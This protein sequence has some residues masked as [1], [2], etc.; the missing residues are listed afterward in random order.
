MGGQDGATPLDEIVR[1]T[2]SNNTVATM[3]QRLPTNLTQAGIVWTGQHAYIFG[4]RVNAT[5]KCF[6]HIW[7]NSIRRFDPATQTFTTMNATLP[8]N[9]SGMAAVWSGQYVYLAGGGYFSCGTVTDQILRYDPA[10]DTLT[11]MNGK[12]T[13]AYSWLSAV[14]MQNKMYTFGGID[15]N[16]FGSPGSRDIIEYDPANDTAVRLGTQIFPGRFGSAAITDG[17]NALVF[18]GVFSVQNND[19]NDDVQRFTPGTTALLTTEMPS[20]FSAGRAFASAVFTGTDAYLIGGSNLAGQFDEIV[21]YKATPA[22]PVAL[23]ASPGPLPQQITLTWTAPDPNSY[24]GPITGYV[25]EKTTGIQTA[26]SASLSSTR[27]RLDLPPDVQT[28]IDSCSSGTMY[29]Y[30]VSAKNLW[31]EGPQSIAASALCP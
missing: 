20:H 2:P 27:E 24:S 5:D 23:T 31:G 11:V 26:G 3:T 19:F 29:T 7:T 6:D 12:L 25:L 13:R 1:Y 17:H 28:Y 4:G 21:R 10:T 15:N 22:S 16:L 8:K 18:T 30:R 14:W 9:I